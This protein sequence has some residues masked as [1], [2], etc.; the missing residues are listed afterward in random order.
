MAEYFLQH[1]WTDQTVAMPL[2]SLELERADR[3]ART[4]HM[5][6]TISEGSP[7]QRIEEGLSTEAGIFIEIDTG[8]RRTGFA[9]EDFDRLDPVLE[10][11]EKSK[12]LR[13]EGFLT[14]SGHSYDARGKEEVEQVHRDSMASLNEL[15]KRY[16]SSNPILSIGDT[17]IASLVEDLEGVD[18]LRPGN[19]VFYDLMM[20]R[21]GACRMEDIAY[22]LICPVIAKHEDRS[23]LL[24]YGGAVH[25]SKD[26]TET[27]DGRACFGIPVQMDANGLGVPYEGSYVRRLSQEMGVV[28][29]SD[30]LFRSKE[31][32]DILAILPVHSCL[33]ADAMDVYLLS[34][35]ERV[36]SFPG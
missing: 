32:G 6:F 22:A 28:V 23:E 2:N 24:V 34:S 1:G 10:R 3:C 33:S 27:E 5:H 21:I 7:I 14:H 29:C 13:F 35:G 4:G 8:D 36:E 25:F 20:E 30:E 18:E 26:R 11:L 16:R 19:F 12:K 15:K 17:P 9:P 31:V